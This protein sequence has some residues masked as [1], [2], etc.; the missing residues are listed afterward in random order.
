MSRSW[1]MYP[2][3]PLLGV[4]CVILSKKNDAVLMIKR[5]SEPDK[6]LWSI[7]GGMVEYGE[8]CEEA[9]IREVNEETSLKIKLDKILKIINKIIYS[10]E[11]IKY[12]F[13]IVD[14]L[15]KDYIGT[16]RASDDALEA[17]WIKYKDLNKYS[18]VPS[19]K[20]L[21]KIIPKM[22]SFVFD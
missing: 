10:S 5:A 21:F 22:Y 7:P 6:G 2:S 13:I 4:G 19:V 17:S 16:I 1:R 15:A 9:T 12:H 20:N 14:Y 8:T 11:K 18:I 3:R